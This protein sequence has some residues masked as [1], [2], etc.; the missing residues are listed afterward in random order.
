MFIKLILFFQVTGSRFYNSLCLSVCLSIC[1]SVGLLVQ[2]IKKCYYV[3]FWS[4]NEGLV[5][6][7]L[8]LRINKLWTED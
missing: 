3:S 8:Q 4:K 1:P 7:A 6:I 2:K 5:K